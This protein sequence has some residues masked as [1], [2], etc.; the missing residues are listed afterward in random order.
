MDGVFVAYHN[1]ARVFGFQYVSLEEMDERLFGP[2]SK[3]ADPPSDISAPTRGAR[4]FEKCVKLLEKVTDEVVGVFG[5]RVSP[6]LLPRSIILQFLML[7][8]FRTER[9][10]HIR[11]ARALVEDGHMG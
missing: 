2:E 7:L 4:V 3:S 5:D 8:T 1:T 6:F 10:M 11:N 9:E